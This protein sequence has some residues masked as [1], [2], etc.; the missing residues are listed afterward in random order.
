MLLP[1]EEEYNRRLEE[2]N[3]IIDVLNAIREE[4]DEWSGTYYNEIGI[5]DELL[6]KIEQN[7][8]QRRTI[9][10]A[11]SMQGVSIFGAER[12]DLDEDVKKSNTQ[13]SLQA[14]E[15]NTLHKNI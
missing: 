14:N 15:D 6:F 12:M 2:L 1:E 11:K 10:E 4:L 7:K 9:V 8:P 5:L 13:I 3:E